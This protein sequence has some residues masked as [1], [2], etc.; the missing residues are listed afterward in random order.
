MGMNWENIRSRAVE[1]ARK[2]PSRKNEPMTKEFRSQWNKML[3]KT[4]DRTLDTNGSTAIERAEYNPNDDSLNIKYKNGN[5]TYKFRAG[6]ENGIREWKSA[7][8]KGRITQEW[9][10]THRYPGF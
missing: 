8:S 4:L 2:A 10:K 6:G 5:K 9:R 3:K 1:N 7:P